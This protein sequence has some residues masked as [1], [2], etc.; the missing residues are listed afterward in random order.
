MSANFKEIQPIK[1][2]SFKLSLQVMM[3]VLPF[4]DAP[5]TITKLK[6]ETL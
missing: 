6:M 5:L 1:T 2:Q 4:Q 3:K